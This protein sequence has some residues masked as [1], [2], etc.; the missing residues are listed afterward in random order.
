MI[1][2]IA[3]IAITAGIAI[4]ESKKLAKLNS[5][6]SLLG[7]LCGWQFSLPQFTVPILLHACKI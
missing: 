7:S 3:K 2:G 4:T 1:G 6:L 5:V